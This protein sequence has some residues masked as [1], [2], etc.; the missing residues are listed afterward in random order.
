MFLQ[1]AEVQAGARVMTHERCT[2]RE[3][4]GSWMPRVLVHQTAVRVSERS[5]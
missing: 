1:T 4:A 2:L 5:N 3:M